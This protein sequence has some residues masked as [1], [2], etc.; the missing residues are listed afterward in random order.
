MEDF[1]LDMNFLKCSICL[2]IYQNP[3]ILPC[4]GRCIACKKCIEKMFNVTTIEKYN[5]TTEIQVVG[6]CLCN[7]PTDVVLDQSVPAEGIEKLIKNIIKRCINYKNGCHFFIS[8][9]M[10]DTILESHTQICGY[11]DFTLIKESSIL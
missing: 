11:V 1:E 6:R 9:E 5:P 2:N 3:Y 4:G 8:S 10:H 7:S